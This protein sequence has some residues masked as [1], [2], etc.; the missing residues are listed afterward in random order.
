MN[1]KIPID[2]KRLDNILAGETGFPTRGRKLVLRGAPL[3]SLLGLAM[4]WHW[5]SLSEWLEP[6]KLAAWAQGLAANPLGGVATVLGFVLGSLIVLPL[7]V[8]IVATA[9][10]FGPVMG[11]IYAV[12]GALSAALVTYAIGHALG[13][14]AACRWAGWRVHQLSERLSKRGILTVI[15][16]RVVPLA[17]FTII[18]FVA[19]ASPLKV[20][21]YFIGSLLGM[22]PGIF[23]MVFFVDGLMAALREPGI[24]RFVFVILLGLLLLVIA[25]VGGY[26]LRREKAESE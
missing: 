22:I 15:F 7:S 2:S 13:G 8:M 5:T 26:W 12:T 24:T 4:A 19:G 18:N 11:F 9:L 21:D 10:I 16:F 14:E 3:M 17:P 20:R 1:S 6:E 25:A 23:A